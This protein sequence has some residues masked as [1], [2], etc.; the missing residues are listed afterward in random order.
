MGRSRTGKASW[1]TS[2][3]FHHEDTKGTKKRD[4]GRA[5]PDTVE[6]GAKARPPR[7]TYK[8]QLFRQ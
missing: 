2:A 7:V 4:C 1:V 3:I 6:A 8:S 5:T